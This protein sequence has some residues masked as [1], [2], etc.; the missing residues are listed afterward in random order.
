M[1]ELLN[2]LLGRGAKPTPVPKPEPEPK[3][4]PILPISSKRIDY[5]GLHA[6]LRTN[7]PVG[8]IFLSDKSYLLCDKA[9]IKAFLA[10]DKTNK[11]EYVTQRFDCD[12]FAYRLMGQ[13]SI[14]GWSDLAFGIMWT[15]KHAMNCMVTIEGLFYLIEPQNDTLQTGGLLPQQGDHIRVIMM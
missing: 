2:W 13:F 10:R 8:E 15:D 7:V 5:T 6:L 3:P 12:D 11:H 4:E 9:D 1:L 14:P